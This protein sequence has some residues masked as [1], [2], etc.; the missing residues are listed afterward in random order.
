MLDMARLIYTASCE[1]ELRQAVERLESGGL[2]PTTV[3][4]YSEASSHRKGRA[5]RAH[6]LVPQSEEDR[7]VAILKEWERQGAAAVPALERELLKEFAVVFFQSSFVAAA[8]F[9]LCWA[10]GWGLERAAACALACGCLFAPLIIFMVR[11]R[12]RAP[13]TRGAPRFKHLEPPRS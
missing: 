10:I 4:E 12:R 8:I 5:F 3:A 7:A 11:S 1:D 6:V 2:S 13:N 9:G